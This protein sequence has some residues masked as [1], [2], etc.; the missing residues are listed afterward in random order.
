MQVDVTSRSDRIPPAVG[1]REARS[2]LER[3]QATCWRQA[4]IIDSL[5]AVIPSFQSGIAALR[6]ENTELRIEN[7]RMRRAL[8]G[9][10]SRQGA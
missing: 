4:R 1:R 2:E 3:A 8:S 7:E 10:A 9:R 5:S 6:A